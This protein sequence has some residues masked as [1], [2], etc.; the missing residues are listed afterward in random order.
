MW[1]KSS[2]YGQEPTC[3]VYVRCLF[4]FYFAL[5]ILFS[6]SFFF[7]VVHV[8]YIFVTAIILI[9]ISLSPS[10][11]VCIRYKNIENVQIQRIPFPVV[12]NMKI[13]F[14]HRVG[15]YNWLSAIFKWNVP[16]IATDHSTQ[17]VLIYI[18]HFYHV[19][20]FLFTALSHGSPIVFPELQEGAGSHVWEI[21][22]RVVEIQWKKK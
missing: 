17:I 16:K 13:I 19:S 6:L 10:S 7:F 15:H 3:V 1:Q 5:W 22:V 14:C 20:L 8:A 4:H 12:V 11:F 21:V 18:F 9:S 2:G